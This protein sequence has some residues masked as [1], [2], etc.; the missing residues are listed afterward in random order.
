MKP[1]RIKAEGIVNEK[2]IDIQDEVILLFGDKTEKVAILNLGIRGYSDRKGY[3]YG[4][5]G[6]MEIS[7]AHDYKKISVYAKDGTIIKNVEMDDGYQ[8]EVLSCIEA[9]QSRDYSKLPQSREMTLDIMA[10]ADEIRRQIGVV[11]P[12][13]KH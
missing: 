13:E 2:G 7:D 4:T 9:I 6:F 11:Y 5:E 12:C 8:Y 1:K 10:V 3:I